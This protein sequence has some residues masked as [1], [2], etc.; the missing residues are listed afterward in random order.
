MINLTT[1]P[2]PNSPPSEIRQF[3]E[4]TVKLAD[5]MQWWKEKNCHFP[6]LAKLAKEILSVP[7]TEISS[8]HAFSMAELTFTQKRA[9]LSSDTADEILFLNKYHKHTSSTCND[10]YDAS[11]MVLHKVSPNTQNPTCSTSA[12]N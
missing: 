4:A 5:P 6:L 7:A 8:E 10:S 9:N 1:Q 3:I 12:N 2:E 11:I